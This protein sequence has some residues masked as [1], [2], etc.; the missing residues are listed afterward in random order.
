MNSVLSTFILFVSA[1]ASMFTLY[2]M[3]KV[4]VKIEESVK[5]SQKTAETVKLMSAELKETSLTSHRSAFYNCNLPFEVRIANGEKYIEEGGN[6]IVKK[7]IE[8]AIATGSIPVTTKC[9]QLRYTLNKQEIKMIVDGRI[10]D[11]LHANGLK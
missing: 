11:Y 3:V 10:E 7:H 8:I 4:A 9:E 2:K 1:A 5:T 6:G